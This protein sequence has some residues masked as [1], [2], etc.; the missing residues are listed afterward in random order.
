MYYSIG[1]APGDALGLRGGRAEGG[2]GGGSHFFACLGPLH[3]R[4]DI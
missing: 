2:R 3:K 1:R 4:R